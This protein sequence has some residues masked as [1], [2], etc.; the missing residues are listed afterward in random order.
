MLLFSAG[1]GVFSKKWTA[2]KTQKLN[3]F[4]KKSYKKTANLLTGQTEQSLE[5]QVLT[6]LSPQVQQLKLLSR[7]RLKVAPL[8]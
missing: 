3:K 5:D 2:Y 4:M 8:R 6:Y 7:K 1:K